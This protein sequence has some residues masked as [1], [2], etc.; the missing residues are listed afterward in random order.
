MHKMQKLLWFVIA[1]LYVLSAEH[2]GVTGKMDAS[3]EEAETKG[4]APETA[5]RGRDV[6]VAG[7]DA[8]ADGKSPAVATID[9]GE[10]SVSPHANLQLLLSPVAVSPNEHF[11][12]LVTA[13]GSEGERRV[14][15]VA[16]FPPRPGAIQSFFFNVSPILAEM[17]AQKTNRISLSIALV[18][19]DRNQ[20]LSHTAVSL[21]GA[22]LRAE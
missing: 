10:G 12:V 21:V 1:S 13:R 14:G 22:R 9:F 5:P 11:L 7:A 2:L 4:A 8:V 17:K 20:Q 3:A 6:L 16:F 15:S 18:P 19:V